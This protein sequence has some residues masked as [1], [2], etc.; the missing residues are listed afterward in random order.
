MRK[1]GARI[2]Y[3]LGEYLNFDELSH[4]ILLDCYPTV[5]MSLVVKHLNG[6][7]TFLLTFLPKDASYS[8][9][10]GFQSPGTF[11][12]LIDPWLNGPSS[13]WHP[14]WL[15]SKHT[16]ESCIS[17]LSQILEPNVVIVS[18]DKPD[19]CHE[20]TLRQLDPA[21]RTTTILAQPAAAKR[22]HG[23]KHFD[24]S[25]LYA[26][27][28]FSHRKPD[29]A[30]RFYIPPIAPGGLPGE[31]T[32]AFIPAKMD[33]SGL[34][35]AI[36]ITYRPPS[37]TA[38]PSSTFSMPTP[39]SSS[40]FDSRRLAPPDP[41]DMPLTPPD[42]P[43]QRTSTLSSRTTAASDVSTLTSGS[44]TATTVTSP[45]HTANSQSVSSA[46]S[47]NARPVPEKTLSLIYSPHGV[48]YNLIR[49]YASSHLV[50]S[51]ALPLTTLLHSFDRVQNPWWLGGNV[52]AGLPGGVEIA[53]SL[54]AKCWISAHDEDKENSGLAVKK[55]TTRKYNAEE[56]RDMVT[57]TKGT[58][59]VVVL[60]CGEEIRLQ[61]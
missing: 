26:L 50:S 5:A 12:V 11:T 40:T 18:Q 4:V 54:M 19:H 22:I 21:S 56:V 34:H 10:C 61:A 25:R 44:T 13:M 23:M 59:D 3:E 27:P 51:A 47:L 8:S 15:L 32:I 1:D 39:P 16:V 38:Q 6:D 37:C 60:A 7:T 20:A 17:D 2:A 52:N 42:S 46:Y 55:V 28:T 43:V 29:S 48:S 31:A 35:N 45:S 36:G 57:K 58:S 9:S 30:I 33:V 24:P 53:H 49:P 14:K 41:H